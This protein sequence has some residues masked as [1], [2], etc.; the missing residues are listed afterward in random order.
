M[1]DM[2]GKRYLAELEQL[3]HSEAQLRRQ[4]TELLDD[5]EYRALREQFIEGDL[6]LDQLSD[7]VD[8]LA[9]TRSDEDPPASGQRRGEG[10]GNP[11]DLDVPDDDL[12]DEGESSGEGSGPNGAGAN[13]SDGGSSGGSAGGGNGGG[14][15]GD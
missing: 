9:L 7:R 8:A 6:T 4:G 11:A 13:G 5:P 15:G 14:D 1:S 2:F 10:A 12:D 3:L